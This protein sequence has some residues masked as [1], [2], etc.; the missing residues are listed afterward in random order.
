M[1]F[2]E[3]LRSAPYVRLLVPYILGILSSCFLRLPLSAFWFIYPFF[4]VLFLTLHFFKV[5]SNFKLSWVWGLSL[6]L[7]IA[8][9]GYFSVVLVSDRDP[10]PASKI[11]AS[12]TILENPVSKTSTYN[13]M[14]K[15]DA[16]NES[17][18]WI[19]SNDKVLCSLGKKAINLDLKLNQQIVMC[20]EWEEIKNYGNPFE[21]DFKKFMN[22]N[23]FY[24]IAYIDS[25][26]WYVPGESHKFKITI[27]ALKIRNQ[28]LNYFNQLNLSP[29]AFAVVSALTVGD[30]SFLDNEI[31]TAYINSGTMHI[32]AVSG[33]HV[34]LLFWLLQQVSRPLMVFRRGKVIRA[35][36]VLV[37]IWVYALITG[38]TPSVVRASVMFSF[39]MLGDTGNRNVNIYNTLSASALLLLVLNPLTL[40][41]VGF[42][43]SYLAVL[44]IVVFYKDIYNWV[45]VKNFIPKYFWS[46]VAVSLAAQLFTLPLTLYYFHQFPNYFLL[47]NIVAL[48]LS[49]IILYGSI[50]ALL[51]APFKFLWL[52]VGWAL[53]HMV[54][55]MNNAL[56]WIEQLPYSVT[57]GITISGSVTLCLFVIIISVRIYIFNRK[58]VN[59]M[60]MLVCIIICLTD[61]AMKLSEIVQSKNIIVYN[62]PGSLIV[63]TRNGN[64]SHLITNNPKYN[65][66]KITKTFNETYLLKNCNKVNFD[67]DTT[68]I[69]NDLL[70]Y[71]GFLVFDEK[72]MFVWDKKPQFSI[73]AKVDV[74]IIT[75]MRYKDVPQI[76]NYFEAKEIVVAPG[77][78]K[79]VSNRIKD[80]FASKDIPCQVV[81]T[82]GAWVWSYTK[83]N[84]K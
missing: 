37:V 79:S 76:E 3:F 47:S 59:V 14:V 25:A 43:L 13:V 34:A 17:G 66:E 35:V 45:L 55:L 4:G 80:H 49:T 20:G 61:F 71:K 6:N 52:P 28:I 15:L 51:I 60:V 58:T 81:N 65:P 27:W 84:G 19:Q 53:K 11:I 78:F 32:L 77:V 70:I 12:G 63:Q 30:K 57:N 16:I 64:T 7:I 48:P 72:K 38:L 46:M 5:S 39:W 50:V 36:L 82:D 42:Q 2:Y 54:D 8:S 41:D 44:G 74:L 40:Y 22:R 24:Y 29:S 67:S 75:K 9:T 62:A 68:I 83:K 18:K 1:S 31:K 73:K 26:N 56:I 21:F 69:Y 10:M 33:M 23:G